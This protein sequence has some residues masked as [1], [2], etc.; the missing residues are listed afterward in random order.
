MKASKLVACLLGSVTFIALLTSASAA[1][2]PKNYGYMTD[3]RGE[4][5][6]NNFGECWHTIDWTPAVAVAEC[7][8][9]LVKQEVQKVEARPAPASVVAAPAEKAAE[10][11][12][13]AIVEKPVRLEGASFALGSSKLLPDAGSKLDEVVSA[14]K[15]HP[16]IN[17]EVVGYTD[18]IGNAQKNLKLSQDRAA[19]V[20]AYLVKKGVAAERISSKGL[21][22][23]SPIADNATAE[24]RTKN[25]RVEVRYAINEEQ[26]V[27]VT[28]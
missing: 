7:E 9:T 25:R 10:S 22:A 12:K 14:A 1:S 16:E 3:S 19:A 6:R 11:W 5:V 13:I 20:K 23:D 28:Q 18:N 24:G 15:Q 21:G 4:I 27:R 26:K 8:A 2:L 17:L